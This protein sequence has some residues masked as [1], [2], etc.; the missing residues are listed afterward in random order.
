MS[1]EVSE[2]SYRHKICINVIRDWILVQNGQPHPT[3]IIYN[4]MLRDTRVTFGHEH[5]LKRFQTSEALYSHGKIKGYLFF[6]LLASVVPALVGRS[7]PTSLSSCRK[8]KTWAHVN[9]SQTMELMQ[10][11]FFSY[12]E[13][14]FK[15]PVVVSSK[16]DGSWF[17]LLQN[18]WPGE[19]FH[20]IKDKKKWHV[21]VNVVF[22]YS[23]TESGKCLKHM[24]VLVNVSLFTW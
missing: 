17:Q 20:P 1:L 3:V 16:R 13:L 9:T 15:A 14:L 24:H 11:V 19:C 23:D 6:S 8:P 7:L 4:Q 18:F 2:R 22:F 21:L 10:G 12:P 5:F